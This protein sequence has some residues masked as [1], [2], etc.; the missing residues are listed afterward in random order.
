MKSENEVSITFKQ[1]IAVN[2]ESLWIIPP[3]APAPVEIPEG[4][5]TAEP[6]GVGVPPPRVTGEGVKPP[7]REEKQVKKAV[8][9]QVNIGGSVPVENWAELFRCFI[10]PAARMQL[11]KLDLKVQFRMEAR[12]D[13]PLCPDA[14]ALKAMREA[15]KQL[16]LNFETNE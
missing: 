5:T 10:G 4:G 6:G 8:V 14:R 7:G 3:F 13:T 1:Y 12:A 16:G 11:K 15:A 2:E 9:R